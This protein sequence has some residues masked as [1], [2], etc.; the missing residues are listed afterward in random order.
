MWVVVPQ[1][2]LVLRIHQAVL[3]G[4]ALFCE[5]VLLNTKSEAAEEGRP[6]FRHQPYH[7]PPPLRTSLGPVPRVCSST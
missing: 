1:V 4:V 6:A 2:G 5:H 3:G 7:L